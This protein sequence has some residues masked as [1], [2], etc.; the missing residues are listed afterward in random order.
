[1]TPASQARLVRIHPKY[2]DPGDPE[3]CRVCAAVWRGL[4]R[5]PTFA[6]SMARGEADIKAGRIRPWTP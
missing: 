3:P 2:H 5:E 6:E 4:M 1:V